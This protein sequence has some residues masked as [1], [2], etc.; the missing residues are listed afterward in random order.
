VGTS[1]PLPLSSPVCNPGCMTYSLWIWVPIEIQS[2]KQLSQNG[3]AGSFLAW[4]S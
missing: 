3:S 4:L 2:R 1:F